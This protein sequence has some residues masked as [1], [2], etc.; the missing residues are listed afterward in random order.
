VAAATL[1]PRLRPRSQRARSLPGAPEACRERGQA[2]WRSPWERPASAAQAKEELTKLKPLKARDKQ[3]EQATPRADLRDQY[4]PQHCTSL[5]SAAASVSFTAASTATSSTITSAAACNACNARFGQV[6]IDTYRPK[7]VLSD[8][9]ERNRQIALT[10]ADAAEAVGRS[11][12]QVGGATGPRHLRCTSAAPPLHLRCTSA[13]PPLHLA[14]NAPAPRPASRAQVALN[15]VASQPAVTA[16]VFA[17]RTAAQLEEVNSSPPTASSPPAQPPAEPSHLPRCSPAPRLPL[18]NGASSPRP[19][20]VIGSLRF[21]LPAAQMQMLNEV[22]A[23]DMG[24]PQRW[25]DG[26]FLVSRNMVVEKRAAS[27]YS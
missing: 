6:G 27:P 11:S 8:W 1:R 3:R 15:W 17:V 22:S 16:P 5:T 19:R 9:T 20:Q 18:S 10:V 21:R 7:A 13:A 26:D 25:K 12:T 24:F 2:F 14:R 23:I 4:Q